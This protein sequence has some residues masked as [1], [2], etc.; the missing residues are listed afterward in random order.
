VSDHAAPTRFVELSDTATERFS[1]AYNEPHECLVKQTNGRHGDQQPVEPSEGG[2]PQNAHRD[3]HGPAD[4]EYRPEQ[5]WC[6]KDEIAR[7]IVVAPRKV[8][9]VGQINKGIF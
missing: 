1:K 5:R 7:I 9:R 2:W 6:E 4:Y 3:S 8:S